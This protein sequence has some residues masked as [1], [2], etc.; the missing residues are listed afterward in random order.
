MGGPQQ[1]YDDG[2]APW[3]RATK[4]LIRSAVANG[5]PTLG[6][7][8]GAQLLAEATGGRVQPGEHGPEVGAKLVAKRDAAA[9][10]P[11]FWDLPLSPVVVQWH[12][13]AVTDLPPAA[14]LL[15][16]SPT[17]PHQAFRVGERA[18]GIQFHIETDAAMVGRWADNDRGDLLE[19]EIDPDVVLGRTVTEIPEIE[20]VWGEVARRFARLALAR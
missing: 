6:V 11:L 1:A 5:L 12:W 7:C 4:E 20:E 18:W 13:D 14:T 17:Y 16:S 15:M 10:D 19:L 2:S 3:L 8:L 9:A